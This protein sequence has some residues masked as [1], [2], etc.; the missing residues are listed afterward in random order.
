MFENN[1]P[2]DYYY[3]GSCQY[4]LAFGDVLVKIVV[5]NFQQFADTA[6]KNC[7]CTNDCSENLEKTVPN[8]LDSICNLFDI[9]NRETYSFK[10]MVVIGAAGITK[11]N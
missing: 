2:V 3:L 8:V 4:V 5:W 6:T 10:I 7:I 1:L 11:D 9:P